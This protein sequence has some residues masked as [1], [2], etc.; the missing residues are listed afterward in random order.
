MYLYVNNISIMQLL[1][2]FYLLLSPFY[3]LTSS[4]GT[5]C[6]N[7]NHIYITY[8]INNTFKIFSDIYNYFVTLCSMCVKLL[9]S[10]PTLCNPM[11]CSQPSSSVHEI[12]QVRIQDWVAISFSRGSSQ[13]RNWTCVS[14]ISCICRQVLY[15]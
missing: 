9:Q 11:D 6:I 14:Y 15:H 5:K 13:P 12:L 1:V 7:Y 10:C 4:F 3:I 2:T 8:V